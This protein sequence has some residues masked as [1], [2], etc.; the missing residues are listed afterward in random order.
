MQ[1]I[2]VLLYVAICAN[3]QHAFAAESFP[4]KYKYFQIACKIE[5]N[6]PDN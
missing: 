6:H 5:L 3:L 1:Q 4:L 2:L